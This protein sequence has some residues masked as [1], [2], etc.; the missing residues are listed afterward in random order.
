LVKRIS[1]GLGP[2]YKR[3]F[4][5]FILPEELE[6]EAYPE[7]IAPMCE[8]RECYWQEG[9]KTYDSGTFC[10]EVEAVIAYEDA[11]GVPQEVHNQEV[12]DDQF[13]ASR[14]KALAS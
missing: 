8:F 1:S 9:L 6:C 4:H 5:G 12:R 11:K 10:Q 13:A 7:G 2:D 3:A 14:A